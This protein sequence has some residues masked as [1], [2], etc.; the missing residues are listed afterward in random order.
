MPREPGEPVTPEGSK[1]QRDEQRRQE[2]YQHE[3]GEKANDK[4]WDRG[5]G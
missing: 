5:P 4:Y 1:E 2:E 3:Q